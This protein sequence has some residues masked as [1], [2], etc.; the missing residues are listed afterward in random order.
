MSRKPSVRYFRCRKAYYCQFNGRQHLLASGPN[1]FP[2]GPTYQ[3]ALN[4][5]NRVMSLAT[6]AANGDANQ[7]QVVLELYLQSVKARQRESTYER[8]YYALIPFHLRYGTLAVGQLTHL[9]FETFLAEQAAKPKDAWG[10][11][12]AAIFLQ[13]A[14]S[15]FNWAVKRKLINN[16]PLRGFTGFRIRSRS[17]ECLLTEADHRRVLDEARSQGMKDLLTA[18][19]LSGARPSELTQATGRDWDDNLGAI[20]YHGDDRRRE[21]DFAHKTS[22]YKDRVIFLT[23]EALAIARAAVARAPTGPLFPSGKG[24]AYRPGAIHSCFKL[25]RQRTGL[26]GLTP[27]SYRHS[28][29]HRWLVGGGSIELLAEILGNTPEVIRKHYGHLCEDRAA[30]RKALEKFLG[31]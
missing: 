15:A 17:R 5:F 13:F 2:N 11:S 4:A 20:V 19:H 14:T 23:G 10:Q 22:R 18:L 30:V 31:G 21:D 16:N 8:K 7:L 28:L 6:A 1:D 26:K 24:K 9:H 25:L 3:K 27:Y 29:A 12:T